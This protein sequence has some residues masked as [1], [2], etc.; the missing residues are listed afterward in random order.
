LFY[1]SGTCQNAHLFIPAQGEPALMVRKS[2]KRTREES[3]LDN[4]NDLRGLDELFKTITA[5]LNGRGRVGLE[6][7]V[8]PSTLR[9]SAT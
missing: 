8:L 7:D 4:I 1:F 9:A 6:M 5:Q 3:A 2:L